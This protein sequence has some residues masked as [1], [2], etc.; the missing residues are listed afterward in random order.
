[1][2]DDIM[3]KSPRILVVD[4]DVDSTSILV[5]L[6]ESS[7]CVAR[8]ANDGFE[9]LEIA[10]ELLPDAVLLDLSLPVLDGCETA[11]RL[12][13]DARFAKTRLVAFSGFSG[14][15]WTSIFDTHLCKPCTFE[16][17][18]IALGLDCSGR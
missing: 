10:K 14:G 5:E 4:D 15:A 7:G 8:A 17:V 13:S 9:A 3:M 1:M 2:G 12:R 6:L 16:E 11:R 18:S